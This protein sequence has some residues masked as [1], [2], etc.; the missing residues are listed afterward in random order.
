[1]HLCPECFVIKTP[2]SKHC[3]VCN[4]CV[5]RYD[6]HCPWINNCVGINNHNS[7]MVFISSLSVT[8][9]AT[10][11]GAVIELI[12]VMRTEQL[13][14][15]YLQ[16]DFLPDQLM[17][18]KTLYLIFMWITIAICFFFQMP[19][20][21]LMYIQVKNYCTYRT[22]YERY[23]KKKPLAKPERLGSEISADSTG[24]SLLSAI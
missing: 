3:N 20:L 16:Y 17:I 7:F 9:V 24:S 2:R 10:F 19:I 8:I 4:K 13:D 12:T 1:M 15:I 22:T 11:I 21:L 14:T 23:A 6:H 18:N 5:E